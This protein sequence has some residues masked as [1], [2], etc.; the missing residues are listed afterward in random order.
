MD[1]CYLKEYM[2]NQ[3]NL[4]QS[5]STVNMYTD[6]V[7]LFIEWFEQIENSKFIPN[8][9]TTID[10]RDYRSYLQNIKHQKAGTINLKLI[11]LKSYFLF[12]AQNKYIEKNPAEKIKKIKVQNAEYGKAFDDKTYRAIR[13]EVYR[14]SNPL[15]IAL[16]EVLTK[17]GCRCSELSNLRLSD[18]EIT[19][20]T[21]QITF[22]GKGNKQ[23][24]MKLHIDAKNA[25]LDYIKVRRKTNP[26]DYLF[27]SERKHKFTR[28]AIWKIINKLSKRA[29]YHV[30]VHQ[31]RHYVLRKLL[32]NGVDL[33]TIS[34]IA[35]HA[36]SLITSRIY[37]VSSQEARDKAIDTLE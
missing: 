23:R 30:T 2:T 22:I 9:V 7:I 15:F 24:T 14:S 3:I 17:T 28:S 16:W 27:L 31:C 8:A 32:E 37:T 29:G 34:K 10:I 26:T 4:D 25:I 12:L 5:E 36:N 18:V 33:D 21:A 1:R 6:N 20:R 19:E 13:R 35:G 11:S